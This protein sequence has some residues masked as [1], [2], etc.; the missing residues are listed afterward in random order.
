[1]QTA[2]I[3]SRHLSR[4]LA[5]DLRLHDWLPVRDGTSAVTLPLVQAKIHEYEQWVAGDALP[6]ER[7]WETPDEMRARLLSAV[8][9]YRHTLPLVLVTHEAPIRSVVGPL[10]VTLGSLHYMP[11]AAFVSPLSAR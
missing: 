2:A 8:R 3:I 11:A 5:V 10:D 1:M 7:T 6:S 9:A 4:P